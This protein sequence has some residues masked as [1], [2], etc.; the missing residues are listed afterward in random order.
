MTPEVGCSWV[1]ENGLKFSERVP[2][3]PLNTVT[4]EALVEELDAGVPPEHPLSTS[5]APAATA[6]TATARERFL[7]RDIFDPSLVCAY[8]GNAIDAATATA[9]LRSVRPFVDHF[10]KHVK[11]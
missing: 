4:V 9:S 10:I 3:D 1:G 5:A 2:T 11:E 7:L 6:I 8:M